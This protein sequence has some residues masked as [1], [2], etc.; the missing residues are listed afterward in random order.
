[1]LTNKINVEDVLKIDSCSYLAWCREE[2][3]MFSS[4]RTHMFDYFICYH[5]ESGWHGP[6]PARVFL[7]EEEE[8][9]NEVDT[10]TVRKDE[11]LLSAVRVYRSI[12]EHSSI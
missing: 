10:E 6:D 12:S 3:I 5:L 9:G 4:K 1:M 2:N 7:S 8:P 11:K